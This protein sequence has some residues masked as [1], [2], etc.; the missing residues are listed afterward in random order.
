MTLR[1]YTFILLTIILLMPIIP[2][3]HAQDQDPGF[4]KQMWAMALINFKINEKWTYNQ[5]IA[6]QHSYET[7]V[8]NRF[9]VRS[10][11]NRQL[12]GSFS[13]HGGLNLTYKFEEYDYDA[14]EIRPWIG[15]KLRWP[16]IWRLNFVQYI[17]FEQRFQN[18]QHV[19]NWDNNSRIRYKISSRIPINHGSLVDKTFYAIMVYEFFSVSFGDDIRFTT[20]ATHRIDLGIGYRQNVKNRY[21]ASFV[22]L[23]GLSEDNAH[24]N[25]SSGV[26]F[27]TYKRYI[28]W[29]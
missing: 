29:E 22:A 18:T 7:P 11:I 4:E 26:L 3:I 6:F 1:K 27:L 16:Y 21:E 8:F 19:D 25:L 15:A 17:R 28:N 24:Y 23:N 2:V 10:Q 14:F 13:V 20:A 9:L 5:D 12:T